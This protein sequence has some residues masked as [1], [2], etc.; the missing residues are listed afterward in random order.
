MTDLSEQ[1]E[2]NKTEVLRLSKE[3]DEE[4][5]KLRWMISPCRFDIDDCSSNVIYCAHHLGVEQG[6]N[7]WGMITPETYHVLRIQIISKYDPQI[8]KMCQEREDLQ[9]G[10]R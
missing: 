1:L 6:S 4:L 5:R 3:R 7:H 10:K 8:L 2:T 9:A